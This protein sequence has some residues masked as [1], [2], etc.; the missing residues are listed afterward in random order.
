MKMF[1][2]IIAI[3]TLTIVFIANLVGSEM[4]E[5]EGGN[6]NNYQSAQNITSPETIKFIYGSLGRGQDTVDYYALVFKQY[7]PQ[8]SVALLVTQDSPETFRP[9]LIF[10]DPNSNHMIGQ[11]PY[12]VPENMGGRIFEWP[13]VSNIKLENRE[14][15]EKFIVGPQLI[16]DMSDTHYLV[17]VYDPQGKG[18]KYTLQIGAKRPEN[19]FKTKVHNLWSIV[20]IKLRL[21]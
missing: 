19:S 8:V 3:I 14:A 20:R 2:S 15:F 5:F 18:G 12:G 6:N 9:N 4:Y 7:T 21:Y 17:A 10:I 13:S 16:K 11:A 1:L